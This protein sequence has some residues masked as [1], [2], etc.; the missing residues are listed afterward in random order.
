VVPVVQE[1]LAIGRRVVPAGRVRVRKTTEHALATVDEPLRHD[2]CSIERVALDVPVTTAPKPRWEGD[3]FVI[4]VVAEVFVKQLR[5]VEEVR[6][7]RRTRTR[8]ERI[9]APLRRNA[10]VVERRGTPVP[11]ARGR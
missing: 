11:I 9:E 2:E 1:E 5:L 8:R 3:T 10:V 4:P 7:T 6:I